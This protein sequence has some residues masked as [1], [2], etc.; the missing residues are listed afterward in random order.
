MRKMDTVHVGQEHFEFV[1]KA[2]AESVGKRFVPKNTDNSTKWAVSNFI[3]WKEKRNATFKNKPKNQVPQGLP[4]FP[5]TLLLLVSGL[6]TTYVVETRMKDCPPKTIYLLQAHTNGVAVLMCIVTTG[7]RLGE[8]VL[9]VMKI[10]TT[11]THLF[12]RTMCH[13][14]IFV[15]KHGTTRPNVG[16]QR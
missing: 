11:H 16:R 6:P 7:T 9:S 13:L 3:A 1:G 10:W 14:Y 5:T 15:T 2:R 8:N 4:S 12:L